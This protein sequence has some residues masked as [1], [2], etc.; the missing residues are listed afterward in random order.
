MAL[1]E[2]IFDVRVVLAKANPYSIL[3]P[4]LKAGVTKV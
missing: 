2:I 3:I 4:D 1:A